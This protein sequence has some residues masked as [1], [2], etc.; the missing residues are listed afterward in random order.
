[1]ADIT[2]LGF[3]RHLRSGPTSHVRHLRKGRLVH[4]GPGQAFWFRSLAAA[5]SEVPVDDREQP[6]L[7]HARTAD[8]QDVVV[9][10]TITYRV[11]DPALA[12]QRV[13][14]G[15]DPERGHWRAAPLEQVGGLLTELA[16]QHALGLLGQM[17][18]TQCLAVGMTSVRER[19][20]SGLAEDGRLGELGIGVIDVRVVAVRAEA[21]VERAL[22]TP[23]REQVQQSADT[24]TFERRASAVQQE[25]AIAE[26]ELQN[27][28]ELARREEQLVLQRGTNERTRAAE[29]AAADR[30]AQEAQAA[31]DRLRADARA[32]ATRVTGAAEGEA[33]AARLAAY[34]G[35]DQATL[36]ALA[37][38][39]LAGQLPDIGT[40]NVTPDLLTSALLRLA[41]GTQE[42]S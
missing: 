24:A 13:D 11:V 1:M 21:D 15:I 29:Q 27:Q 30:I 26:N 10:A 12:A 23:T 8:F 20:A 36:L 28:I 42:E 17:T 5:L 40:L 39:E 16:Q 35:V 18:L 9:Q 22:Q 7:F 33:E 31:T 32:D 41:T 4:D 19:I 34:T 6:L 14:F 38:R 2:S 25:R 3:A 37:L